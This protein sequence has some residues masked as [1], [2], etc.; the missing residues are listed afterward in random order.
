MKRIIA[1]SIIALGVGASVI[2]GS[3]HR[4]T[5]KPLNQQQNFAQADR[6]HSTNP[7]VPSPD[8]PEEAIRWRRLA[9]VNEKNEIPPDALTAAINQREGNTHYWIERGRLENAGIN[10]SSWVSRGPQN[11]G[12]RTR[13]LV[14]HPA[15]PNV[16]WAGSVSGGVWRSA[17]GGTTWAP[18]DDFMLNLSA[19]CI[20]MSPTDPNTLYC[21][22]GEG[23]FNVDGIQGA[24]IFKTTNGGTTWSQ[25][26]STADWNTTGKVTVNRISIAPGNSNLLLAGTRYGGI[27]RS[28]DAGLSWTTTYWAQGCYF[29]A[30]H[31]TDNNK[32]IAHVIDYDFTINNWFHSALYS[33]DGGATWQQSNV[34][35]VFGFGARIELAYAPPNPATVYASFDGGSGGKIWRSTDGG[36]NYSQMTTS[37]NTGVSWYANPLWVSPTNPDFL[38]TGGYALYKSTNAGVSFTQISDGY[39]L[40][41]EPH[42]DQHF[43]VADP[44]FNG[45]NNKRVY[46]CNDGGVFRTDDIFSANTT[47]GWVSL[48]N[49]YQTAQYY[50]AAGH[51]GTNLIIGGTQDNGTLRTPV[52]S[53]NATLMFGGDGGFAAVDPGDDTYCYGEY[54]N[55]QIHRS[56]NHGVSSSSIYSGLTDAENGNANFIAPFILDPNDSNRMLAGGASLWRSNNVRLGSPPNWSPIRSAGSDKISAI[57]VAPGNSNII[58]VAQNDGKVYKTNNGLSPAPAWTTVDDN[59]ATNP[60]PDRYVARLLIDPADPNVVYAGLGGF[61]DGNLQRTTNGGVTWTDVT[62]SGATGLP[63]APV[64]GIARHPSNPN[65]LYVG[66]EVGIFSSEDAGV[67]WSAT[68]EGPANV[69]VDELVFMGNSNV[70]LAATHGRGVWTA[71]TACP[72]TL[73]HTSESYPGKGGNGTVSVTASDGCTWTATTASPFITIGSHSIGSI[74]QYSVAPNPGPTIRNGTITI[75]DQTFTVYQGI[76]F[77]DVPLTDQ[78]YTEIGKLSAR[79]VTLGCGNGNY[80]PNDPVTREQMAAFIMRAKGEFNPPTPSSQRF[81]DVPPANPFYNFIDRLAVLQITL[82]CTPD[83]LMYCPSD[84]VKREQMAAFI[85]RGLGEFNPPTPGSQRFNDVPPSNVFY[86]FID[87]MA[88]LNITLGCTPDHLFYCPND[89][90]TRAQMAAFLVR[91]FNL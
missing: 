16:L 38:I 17:N 4:H 58:W 62:G 32:A 78:F 60:L 43:V 12:G 84:P 71:I 27:Q 23:F 89:S 72:I 52:S 50:G 64:R 14:I 68:S 30:F 45:T 22:T 61:S 90:V 87:R 56:Q 54:V 15:D 37:G 36:H 39:L 26:L 47:S 25:L 5:N 77:A 91:A 75:G 82:G 1:V 48:N 21:G 85:V 41:E 88:V 69:S 34:N 8:S 3:Y 73:D 19:N 40:T 6:R 20:A 51:G 44:A 11:V 57:A 35:H 10:S 79:G 59:G 55:L 9:W 42:P 65:W 63:F 67:T 81:V 7:K 76:N 31:P 46:V 49:T 2:S 18:T 28:T 80:C 53:Q 13:S 66:T 70:L 24:G 83:H 33:S 74:V 29:V 86:N